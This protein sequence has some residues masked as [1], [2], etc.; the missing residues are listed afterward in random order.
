MDALS[1]TQLVAI[2]IEARKAEHYSERTI[3]TY[4]PI[5]NKFISFLENDELSINDIDTAIIR[6]FFAT[7]NDISRKTA[8][9]Y[10]CAL[11]SLWEWA[12]Q[13]EYCQVENLALKAVKLRKSNPPE[14]IPFTRTELLDLLKAAEEWK[15]P[16]LDTALLLLL[17]DTG[18]RASELCDV[19]LNDVYW[20][21]HKIR[22]HGKG[23]KQRS[24]RFS[25]RTGDAMKTYMKWR[26]VSIHK[27]SAVPLFV[28]EKGENLDRHSLHKIITRLGRHAEVI[29]THAHRFRHTFAI[30][31]LRNGGN[32]YTLQK[33]LGHTTLE[34][35]K[36][37]LAVAQVDMDRGMERASPV[38]G[39]EL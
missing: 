5:F 32:I 30:E 36:R 21:S 15:Y 3:T 12:I 29:D 13:N 28:N 19:A 23:D 2:Y 38:K 20:N 8:L 9:N 37:Y 4:Q 14:I 39:W 26:G 1:L 22:I 10:Q 6:R 34:M 17:L 11:S 18:V 35:C 33:L 7:Y 16:K 31:F 24:L 25:D 27:V